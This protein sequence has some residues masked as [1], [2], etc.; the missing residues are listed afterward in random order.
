MFVRI[1]HLTSEKILHIIYI[2]NFFKKNENILN[3]SVKK[4]YYNELGDD[5]NESDEWK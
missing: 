1:L 4:M 3:Y 2:P 5:E